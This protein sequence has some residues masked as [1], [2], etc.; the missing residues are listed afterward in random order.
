LQEINYVSAIL[1]GERTTLTQMYA[2]LFPFIRRLVK[3][4]GGSDEDAKDV[5]QDA[6]IVVYEK[7]KKPD[8][9]LTSKF[10]TYFYSI[11]N[12]IWRSRLQK[13]SASE[14]T[15]PDHAKFIP[16][17]SS[18]VDILQIERNK[19]FYK[20]LRLM[21]KNCQKLLELFFQKLS[22]VEIAREMGYASEGYARVQKSKCKDRLVELVKNTAEFT[23]LQSA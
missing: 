16:D 18:D 5:F 14:V 8:F 17:D 4:L 2:A 19:L 3:D 1:S 15:I 23:E 21:G 13:K 11:C 12:N 7:A 22:M 10:S 6:V 20:T 9:E